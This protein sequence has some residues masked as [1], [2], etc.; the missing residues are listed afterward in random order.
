MPVAGNVAGIIGASVG[1]G[2]VGD[3]PP[4]DDTEGS[5]PV[6]QVIEPLAAELQGRA[7]SA[8]GQSGPTGVGR[9]AATSTWTPGGGIKQ[10][11]TVDAGSIGQRCCQVEVFGM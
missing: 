9:L 6:R 4:S 1:Q 2:A 8:Q 5:L 11:D 3:D 7:L 10:F